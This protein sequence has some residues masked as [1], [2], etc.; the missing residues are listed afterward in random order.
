MAVSGQDEGQISSKEEES[1]AAIFA[2]LSML[3]SEPCTKR[4]TCMRCRRPIQVCI[5]SCFPKCPIQIQTQII[6]LQ[7]KNEESRS[8]ATV[9][10]LKEC[11]V[12]EKVLILRG[13][14]F[15]PERF[16]L[17]LSAVQSPKTLILYPG[18][19]AIDLST[20]PRKPI[21]RDD[22]SAVI[23]LDGTWAQTKSMFA[24]NPYLHHIR[25]VQLSGEI[26]SE[27][28]IRTQP[29]HQSLS[30]L[31]SVAYMLDWFEQN[32]EIVEVLVRP[33]R[34]LCQHQLDH[35]ALRHYSKDHPYYISREEFNKQQQ[36]TRATNVTEQNEKHSV[37]TLL[38]QFIKETNDTTSS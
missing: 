14:R 20:L 31:E 5:C 1:L 22:G 24:Q 16:P 8:L 9:P 34:A 6:I 30:T 32:P 13:K 11:L 27:Y 18:H 38:Q 37:N 21:G 23:V 3:P 36:T 12:K 17:L 26:S 35:G 19:S 7:H 4:E 29:T 10:L 33:L 28:I 15:R 25:N 2:E